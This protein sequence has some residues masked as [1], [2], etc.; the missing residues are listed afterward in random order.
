MPQVTF[1][2]DL[3]IKDISQ[4]PFPIPK[5][6]TDLG[7]RAVHGDTIEIRY[8]LNIGIPSLSP[9]ELE[10]L[11]KLARKHGIT[12]D[13]DQLNVVYKALDTARNILRRL[14]ESNA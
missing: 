6:S 4:S 14:E 8:T 11:I 7:V 2:L 9:R 10:R 12:Y 1:R 13:A 5:I 3:P